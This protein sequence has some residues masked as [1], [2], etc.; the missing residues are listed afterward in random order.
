MYIC[1]IPYFA[2]TESIS[3]LRTAFFPVDMEGNI[4]SKLNIC[5]TGV[6]LDDS[7]QALESLKI[8]TSGISANKKN[9]P[10][11]MV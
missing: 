9:L 7:A 2:T 1:L 10:D 4:L 5:V 3:P 11:K 6:Q 8:L